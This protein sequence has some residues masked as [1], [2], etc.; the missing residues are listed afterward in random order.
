LRIAALKILDVDEK[1]RVQSKGISAA[2]K[3]VHIFMPT[4]LTNLATRCN[5]TFLNW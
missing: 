2:A 5:S 1:D 4:P 3:F